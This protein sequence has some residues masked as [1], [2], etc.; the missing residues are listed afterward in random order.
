M[1]QTKDD[2]GSSALTCHFVHVL[3]R[4]ILFVVRVNSCYYSVFVQNTRCE[5]IKGTWYPLQY[6][7]RNYVND[8][9]FRYN[10][11]FAFIHARPSAL[12]QIGI[13]SEEHRCRPSVLEQD[14]DGPSRD[15]YLHWTAQGEKKSKL[16][17]P[18]CYSSPRSRCLV[19][20]KP[21]AL[22]KSGGRNLRNRMLLTTSTA[23]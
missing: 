2:I 17:Y 14:I 6:Y 20:F 4:W 12:L 11:S 10:F 18:A 1:K 16:L 3:Y 7:L 22:W 13:D 5:S 23:P 9:S 15:L 21:H 8:R 19:G